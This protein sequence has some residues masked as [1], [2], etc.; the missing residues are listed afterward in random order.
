MT[1]FLRFILFASVR[2]FS[3]VVNLLKT[4]ARRILRRK[5]RPITRNEMKNSMVK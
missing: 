5:K 2:S 4:L 3:L 1:P